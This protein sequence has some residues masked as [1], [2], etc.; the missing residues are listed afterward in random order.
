MSGQAI[1]FLER[2]PR[3]FVPGPSDCW[4]DVVR[5]Q[6]LFDPALGSGSR[7]APCCIRAVGVRVKRID[8]W[9]IADECVHY[10]PWDLAIPR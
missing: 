4:G 7:L 8:G 5:H 3:Q 9:G 1:G 6:E 2:M 10:V